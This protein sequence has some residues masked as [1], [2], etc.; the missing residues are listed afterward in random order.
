[1]NVIQSLLTESCSSFLEVVSV[2]VGGGDVEVGM[3]VGSGL[4]VEL[5]WRL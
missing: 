3:E 5:D 2:I 1:M 4:V